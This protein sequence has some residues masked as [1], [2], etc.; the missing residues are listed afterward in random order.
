MLTRK[1]GLA[2]LIAP[3]RVVGASS[4]SFAQDFD[5][6]VNGADDDGTAKHSSISPYAGFM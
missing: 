4:M 6:S 1:V 3:G 5:W 2:G